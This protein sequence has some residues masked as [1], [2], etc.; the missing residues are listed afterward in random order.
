MVSVCGGR[1]MHRS[2]AGTV[3][4]THSSLYLVTMAVVR[5]PFGSFP[6]RSLWMV[7][8]EHQIGAGALRPLERERQV[9]GLCGRH[10]ESKFLDPNG[11]R[12]SRYSTK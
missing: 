5:P 3:H 12:Y 1:I 8:S 2:I 6:L 7:I 10:L 9:R 4:E 11:I